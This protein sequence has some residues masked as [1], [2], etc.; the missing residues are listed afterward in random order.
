M[1]KLMLCAV[2]ALCALGSGPSFAARVTPMAID[3]TPTGRG[4][5]AR[6]EVT[7]NE[8]RDIPMEVR[9]YRGVISES[10]QLDLKPADDR[11]VAFPPQVVIPA[12]GQQVFRVQYL[13]D[14]PLAQSEVFYAAITQLPVE[15]DPTVSK[16]QLLMRFNVLLN[17]V[18]DGTKAEPIVSWVRVADRKA[19]AAEA[20]LA[21]KLQSDPT[22]AERGVDV[23]IENR[24]NR[25]F[26]AGQ[27]DWTIKGTDKAGAPFS[28]SFTSAEMGEMIGTGV[29]APGRARVF[30]IPLDRQLGEGASVAL[31]Y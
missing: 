27:A 16:I 24:G 25:Y 19:P 10:G 13:P 11:F 31:K 28:K 22:L 23:R 4:S 20:D 6:I 5:V 3:M 12:N 1:R 7:N 2:A 15:T 17:V 8:N 9:L 21:K 30:F 29:V 14:G 26:A 18:P